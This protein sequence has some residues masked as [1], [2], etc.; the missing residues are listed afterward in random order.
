MAYK[1]F[2]I[3]L[4]KLEGLDPA[5]QERLIEFERAQHEERQQHEMMKDAKRRAWIA[6]GGTEASF[7]EDWSELLGE[8]TAI[9]ERAREEEERARRG[10][11]FSRF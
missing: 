5:D 8:S 2:K 10:S 11:I 3:G 6:A 4:D 1:P 9:A 7:E